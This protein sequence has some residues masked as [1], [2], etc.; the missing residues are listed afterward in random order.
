MQRRRRFLKVLA[1]SPLGA[2][3]CGSGE[4]PDG[5]GGGGTTTQSSTTAGGGAEPGQLPAG[6]LELGHASDVPIE[7]LLEHPSLDLLVGR[8]A[9]GIYVMTS[10]CTHQDCNMIGHEGVAADLT[11]TCGCHGSRFDRFGQVEK[12]PA[13]M[14]LPHFH[15]VITDDGLMG[16]D[17]DQL[18]DV[19]F[20]V[21]A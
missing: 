4:V 8:D 20:R 17:L 13:N 21:P 7:S 19:D 12:G 3:G 15:V 10:R 18:V 2:L 14:T 6:Y 16:V 1:I 11:I 9:G 5:D